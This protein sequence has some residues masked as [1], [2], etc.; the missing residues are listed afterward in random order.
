[1]SD[2]S[3]TVTTSTAPVVDE[4]ARFRAFTA[5]GLAFAGLSGGGI[6]ASAFQ[7]LVMKSFG[8]G[9]AGSDQY[10]FMGLALG[11]V[12]MGVA[13][14]WLASTAMTTHDV[15]ARPIARVSLVFA[16][17]AICGAVLLVFATLDGM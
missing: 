9:F 12:G 8:D 1:M 5:L 7:L 13:A 6:F 11:P 17:L 2:T 14:L 4:R 16:G 10:Y 3:E 15:V